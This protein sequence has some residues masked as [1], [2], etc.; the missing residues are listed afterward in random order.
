MYVSTNFIHTKG[1]S[2]FIDEIPPEARF[3]GRQYAVSL[4][5]NNQTINKYIFSLKS[6]ASKNIQP[7]QRKKYAYERRGYTKHV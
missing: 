2:C 1:N 3:T 6:A 5:L 7:A 4:Q